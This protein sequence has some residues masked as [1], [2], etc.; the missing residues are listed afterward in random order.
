MFFTILGSCSFAQEEAF[1]VLEKGL[2][3]SLQE[4]KEFLQYEGYRITKEDNSSVVLTND[5]VLV[6]LNIDDDKNLSSVS[7][8]SPPSTDW[9]NIRD[10]YNLLKNKLIQNMGIPLIPMRGMEIG[11]RIPN[12]VPSGRVLTR[13]K[14]IYRV[15]LT[16][17]EDMLLSLRGVCLK[18]QVSMSY[19]L[20]RKKKS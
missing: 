1:G 5:T 7:L 9:E 12:G 20:F 2:N 6:I 16:L 17:K 15:Y 4:V 8:S 14:A 13:K 11:M 19:F 3:A 10:C 18:K